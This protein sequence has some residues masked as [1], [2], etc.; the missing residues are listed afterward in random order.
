M[1]GKEHVKLLIVTPD[2]GLGGTQGYVRKL[3]RDISPFIST[4]MVVLTGRK[5]VN[6]YKF[7]HSRR[8]LLS[9]YSLHIYL[10]E[11]RPNQILVVMDHAL[12][13]VVVANLF[14]GSQAKIIYRP[15]SIPSLMSE[16]YKMGRLRLRIEKF[17]MNCF[18]SKIVFQSSDQASEYNRV[19]DHIVIGNYG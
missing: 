5:T 17:L 8:V 2:L 10:K 13:A 18:V 7:L 19:K 9:I 6:N 4:R 16:Y 3:E 11:I 1:V 12:L 15:S 14:T